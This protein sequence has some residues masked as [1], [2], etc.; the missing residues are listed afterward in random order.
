MQTNDFIFE[1]QEDTLN[2]NRIRQFCKSFNIAT[3]LNRSRIRKAK[4]FE[5]KDIF[6]T[7]FA[8]PFF[9]KDLFHDV[10]KNNNVPFGKDAVYEFLKS[11]TFNWR[12]FTK[13]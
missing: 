2:L 13:I 5:A 1:G 7:L 10:I 11:E 6:F 12:K 3:L 8:L 4:G 9:G